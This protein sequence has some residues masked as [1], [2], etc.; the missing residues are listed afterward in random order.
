MT[1]LRRDPVVGRWVVMNTDRQ[2]GPG[3]F[4]KEDHVYKQEATCQFCPHKE[5]HTPDEVF[6][7]R[8]DNSEE[9]NPGW[10]VRVV[11]NKFP[12]LQRFISKVFW[13]GY[14]ETRER[15]IKDIPAYSR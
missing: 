11:P 3:D 15:D 10:S 5:N 7:I 2:L 9:N 14:R 4:E 1:E 8:E 12:A 6:A 13:Y